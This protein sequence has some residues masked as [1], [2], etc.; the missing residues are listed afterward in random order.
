M[1]M[2]IY[3]LQIDTQGC[4]L[5]K[6]QRRCINHLNLLKSFGS[7]LKHYRVAVSPLNMSR[8]FVLGLFRVS[9]QEQ[10]LRFALVSASP[11]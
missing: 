8:I 6:R 5:Q 3:M 1:W 11:Q 9:K 2:M 4:H 10:H 7:T